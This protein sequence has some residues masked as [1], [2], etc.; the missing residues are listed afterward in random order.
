MKCEACCSTLLQSFKPSKQP[1]F[2]PTLYLAM[3]MWD[4][5]SPTRDRT[6]APCSGSVGSSPLDHRAGPLRG[7]SKCRTLYTTQVTPQGA[8]S[9]GEESVKNE[10][11]T[12][13]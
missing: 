8:G 9:A 1:F 11:T 12:E 4:L 3:C 5:R 6:W 7:P 10:E 13:S 2:F